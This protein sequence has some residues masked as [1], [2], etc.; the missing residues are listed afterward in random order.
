MKQIIHWGLVA[1]IALSF[2]AFKSNLSA[3][4]RIISHDELMDKLSGFWIGQI[5]GNYVGFPFENLYVEEPI[6]ILVDQVYTA[7]YDGDLELK[8]NTKDRRG[9][10]PTLVDAV[11]GAFSDDDTDIEFVTLHAVEKYGL[12]ITYPEITQMWKTHINDFI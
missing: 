5:L 7:D 1:V 3:K 4:E 11:R 12:D 9:H 8:I 6:P 10:I 2:L